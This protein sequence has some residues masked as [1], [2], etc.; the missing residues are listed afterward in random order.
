MAK[1]QQSPSP[2]TLGS[3]VDYY[4]AREYEPE[5]HKVTDTVTLPGFVQLMRL[6]THLPF[7]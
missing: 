2:C 1:P 4:S 6:Q 7:A 3:T 5:E